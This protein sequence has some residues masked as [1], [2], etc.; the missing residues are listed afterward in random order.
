M[1]SCTEPSS[2]GESR[3]GNPAVQRLVQ[4]RRLVFEYGDDLVE[5]AVGEEMPWSYVSASVVVRSRDHHRPSTACQ[6]QVSR[7]LP[8]GHASGTL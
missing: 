7:W 1:R 2:T 3:S 8:A 4:V 6:K 5:V